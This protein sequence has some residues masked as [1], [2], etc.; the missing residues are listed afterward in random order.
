M[1]VRPTNGVN[2]GA[3]HTITSDGVNV[4]AVAEVVTLV[5]TAGTTVSSNVTI[6]LPSLAPVV[7]AVLDTDDLTTEVATKVRAGTFTGWTTGGSASTV[8]FTKNVAGAVTG[9][10]TFDGGT[11]GA[12]ATITVSTNGADAINGYVDFDFRVADDDFHFDLVAIANVYRLGVLTNPVDLS[13]KYP[14]KGVVRVDGTL[15]SG[16]VIYLVAQR[17]SLN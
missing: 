15:V 8:T 11:T 13:I 7:I 16:D 17:D 6:T 14:N 10:P 1:K 5:V 2:F 12:T 4:A 9:V 3:K